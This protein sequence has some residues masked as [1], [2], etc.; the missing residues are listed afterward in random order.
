M[1]RIP[2][3]LLLSDQSFFHVTW[4]CHNDDYLLKPEQIKK[5]L[6]HLLIKYKQRYKIKIFGYCFMNNHPHIVG[7]CETVKQFSSFFQSVNSCLAKF[8]NLKLGRKGQAIMDRP[9]SP[10]IQSLDHLIKTLHYIDMNPVRAKICTHPNSYRWSSY[11]TFAYGKKDVLLDPLPDDY[12]L[13]HA[14]YK[15]TSDFILKRGKIYIPLYKNA[16]FIG[17]PQWVK[18]MRH[19]LMRKIV[20][21]RYERR[22]SLDPH[23]A[24]ALR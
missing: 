3:K 7:Y 13:D 1:A 11:K 17:S 21:A 6:Y 9:K 2:R 20:S 22:H 16:Y 19:E 23:G 18:T 4:K 15:E 14:C 24:T 10:Q 12:S 8:I 5:K